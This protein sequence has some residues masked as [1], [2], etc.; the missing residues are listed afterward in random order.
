[1]A[2]VLDA[3]S[4]E[5]KASL[6]MEQRLHQGTALDLRSQIWSKL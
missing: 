1:M 6:T 4:K 2:V 5:Y 3:A